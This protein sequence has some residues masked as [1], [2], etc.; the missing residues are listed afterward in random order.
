M[1]SL[2]KEL[3]SSFKSYIRKE[4]Y[5]IKYSF[6]NDE[7]F[8]KK[9]FKNTFGRYP[10]LKDPKTLNEKI[11]WLKLYSFKDFY[12]ECCDKYLARDYI[13]KKLGDSVKD[14]LVPLY[15]ETNDWHTIT[16]EVLPDQPFVIKP[17]HSCGDYLIV[18]NKEDIDINQLRKDCKRWLKRDYYKESRERQYKDSPRRIIIEKLLQ[19]SDGHI[20]N[21]YKLHYINGELQFVYCSV[22]RETKNYRKI[23]SPDW[24]PLPFIW[25]PKNKLESQSG[26]DDIPA[27]ASFQ[28]MKK[29]ASVLAE[30]FEYVRIDF[31]DVDG[32]LYFGEI[33]LYHGGGYDVFSPDKYDYYYGDLL[34]LKM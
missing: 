34:K 3:F 30:D 18:K 14:Y 5:S 20:P 15:Y 12:V 32:H 25:V 6:Y 33:T 11:Q 22:A 24:E 26:G 4:Y 19:T 10:D 29:Y 16:M 27:P 7:D 8:A 17:T 13:L 21:D 1:N 23:Y 9:M 2:I 28:L 31:Y